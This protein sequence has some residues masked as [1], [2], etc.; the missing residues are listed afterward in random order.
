MRRSAERYDVIQ[1][2]MVDTWAATAAGA[3]ALTENNLYTVEAFKEY[4]TRLADGGVLSMT[5]WHQDP[6]D[7][8][9][10]LASL[11]RA[12]MSELGVSQPERH[13]I[14]VRGA[15]Q[16]RFRR[17]PATFL[18]KRGPFSEAESRLIERAAA[19][20]GFLPLYTPLHRPPGDL[21]RLLEAPDPATVWDRLESDVRPTRDNS[22][23]FFHSLRLRNLGRA[24]GGSGEWRKTNLGTF[25]L[26]VLVVI[27]LLVTLVF[28]FG[29]LLL[30]RSRVA[31]APGRRTLPWLAFFFSLGAGFILVEVALIQKFILFL[32]HPAQA[33]SVVLFALLAWSGLGSRL[34]G[35]LVES[36]CTGPCPAC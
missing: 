22:P 2:T 16:R 18:L 30:T 6:P 20:R 21:T 5:R 26:A 17:A 1:A 28:I 33:L 24:L 8:L 3:F 15:P 12:A 32:G 19:E 29:P 36:G 27:T 34:S 9:L 13:V 7:Q 4:W 31:S 35:Q 14:V 25:V 11:A 23:F 10:R